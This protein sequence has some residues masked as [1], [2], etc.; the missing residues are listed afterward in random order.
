MDDATRRRNLAGFAALLRQAGA[1]IPPAVQ[2][3]SV[4]QAG[5][6]DYQPPPQQP[7][8]TPTPSVPTPQPKWN[9]FSGVSGPGASRLTGPRRFPVNNP[10]PGYGQ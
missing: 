2:R 6:A 9:G 5:M 10:P 8:L 4:P 1:A 7:P 3:E